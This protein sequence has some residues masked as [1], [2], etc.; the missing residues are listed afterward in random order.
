MAIDIAGSALIEVDVQNDF[1]PAYTTKNGEKRPPGALA[2]SQGD[3]VIKPLNLMA[4]KFARS[5][6]KIIVSQDWHPAHHSSFA[7]SHPGKQVNDIMVLP[8]PRLADPSSLQET[9]LREFAPA[10]IQQVLWPDHCVQNSEGA[11]FH[12]DLNLEHV[13][14]ILRKGYRRDLDSYSVFFEN[15]RYTPTGL[16]G[17]LKGLY[18]NKLF[19]GGLAT[20]YCVLYS[21]MDAIRLGYKV[22]VLTD[23][24][25]GVDVPVG[26]VE[27]AFDM[28]R[29]AG[30]AFMNSGEVV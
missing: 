17:F 16:D 10:A 6:G 23:A 11:R 8:V 13:N 24:V 19:I 7:S 1:C 22:V 28:M 30:V 3:E 29:Q 27:R 21:V 9:N 18:I 5:G 20:D 12:D 25:C 14:L 4:E 2:V 26:S 15:D